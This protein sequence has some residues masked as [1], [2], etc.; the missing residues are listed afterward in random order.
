MDE[1]KNCQISRT[2]T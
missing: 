2:T 1:V